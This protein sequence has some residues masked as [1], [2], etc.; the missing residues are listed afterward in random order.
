MDMLESILNA[1][2][3]GATRQLGK[4]FG[5]DDSQVS[6]ALSALVPAL[7]AGFQRNMSSPQ[8]LEGLIWPSAAVSINAISTTAVR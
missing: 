6:S 8:G 3:G 4:Q 2:G 5:L 7:A 1:Q